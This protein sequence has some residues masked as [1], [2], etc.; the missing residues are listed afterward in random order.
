MLLE[1]SGSNAEHDMEKFNNFLEQGISKNEI[2]D[3]TITAEVGKMQNIWKLRELIAVA[4]VKEGYC[5][6]YDISLPLKDF[7]NI[8]GVMERRVGAMATRVCGYGHLGMRKRRLCK[9]KNFENNFNF[10]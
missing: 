6:K 8:V 10:R 1:T 9:S 7:Y 4:C 5:F 2:M 3:G